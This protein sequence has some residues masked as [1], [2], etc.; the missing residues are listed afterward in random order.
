M[1]G[2][3]RWMAAVTGKKAEKSPDNQKVGISGA[4]L[5]GRTWGPGPTRQTS[6][7]T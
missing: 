6:T 7:S 1:R 3:R 2:E 4:G 5:E